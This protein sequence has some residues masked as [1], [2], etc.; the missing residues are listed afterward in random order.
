MEKIVTV[1]FII[2]M[3]DPVHE[4]MYNKIYLTSPQIQP[5]WFAVLFFLPS[6]DQ[7]NRN[8]QQMEGWG[9]SAKTF[10]I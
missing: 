10:Q 9:L 3:Y 5:G 4:L 7:I 2:K 1:P 6:E 8:A